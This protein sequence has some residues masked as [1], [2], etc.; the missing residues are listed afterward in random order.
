[1]C[2]GQQPLPSFRR[3]CAEFL[4]NLN[5]DS[6]AEAQSAF[7]CSSRTHGLTSLLMYYFCM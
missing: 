6:C 1:M 2:A 5:T 4:L 7:R 3:A